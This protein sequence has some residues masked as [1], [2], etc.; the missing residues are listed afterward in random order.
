[1]VALSSERVD[2][3]GVRGRGDVRF[4][5]LAIDHV[6]RSVEQVGDVL[7]QAGVAPDADVGVGIE[8]DHDVGVAVGA[9]VAAGAR[10]E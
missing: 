2:G 9:G 6:Y 5:G 10:A 4:E 7:F 1:M 3:I 8:F